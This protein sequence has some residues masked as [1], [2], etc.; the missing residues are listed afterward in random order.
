MNK[1]LPVNKFQ[2]FLIVAGV[3]YF[4]WYLLYQF[5]IHPWKKV[6]LFVINN[7]ISVSNHILK[8]L[9]YRTFTGE[10][11]VIGVDGSPG[12]WIGDKCNGVELFALFCVFIIAYPGKWK[13]KIIYLGAGVLSVHA[14]NIL[15]VVGLAIVQHNFQDWTEFNHT[16][17]FN[18]LVYGYIFLL[19]MIWANKFSGEKMTENK[20]GMANSK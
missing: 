17:I 15:R 13:R 3:V 10:E 9:N 1:F 6:D 18:T 12:L 16:Y 20:S 7:T 14:I 19:W 11:R 4:S 2:R 5:V 8:V